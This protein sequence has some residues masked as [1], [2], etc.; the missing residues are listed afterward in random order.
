VHSRA[1]REAEREF[2]KYEEAR[3]SLKHFHYSKEV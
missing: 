2:P 1:F 3:R